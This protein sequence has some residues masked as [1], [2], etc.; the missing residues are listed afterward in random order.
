MAADRVFFLIAAICWFIGGMTGF[1]GDSSSPNTNSI[2][3]RVN[4]W[5]LGAGFVALT[6]VF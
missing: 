5:L 1:I 6:F 4:W 2:I 3:G